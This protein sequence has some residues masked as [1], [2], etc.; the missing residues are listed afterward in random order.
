MFLPD[1]DRSPKYDFISEKCGESGG[2]LE[3]QL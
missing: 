1:G 3:V 2:R